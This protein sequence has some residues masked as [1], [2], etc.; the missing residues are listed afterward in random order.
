MRQ[1]LKRLI[2]FLCLL[3]IS[4]SPISYTRTSSIAQAQVRSIYNNGA[5]GLG[6]LLRRLQT[7][8]SAMHTGAHPDDEDSALI[9]RLAG[10]ISSALTSSSH[11]V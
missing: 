9:A 1:S 6:Q 4:T 5:G 10:R 3:A 8:A 11:S 2:T 7:T